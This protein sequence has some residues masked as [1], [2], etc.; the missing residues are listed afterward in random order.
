[1]PADSAR[2]TTAVQMSPISSSQT[3]YTLRL[4]IRV[5]YGTIGA[6]SVLSESISLFSRYSWLFG[7]LEG[8]LGYWWVRRH[9]QQLLTMTRDFIVLFVLS[10]LERFIRGERFRYFDADFSDSFR[11]LFIIRRFVYVYFVHCS[12]KRR[13]PILFTFVVVAFGLPPEFWASFI[14]AM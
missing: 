1:M 10:K 4:N 11:F 5:V 3:L 2:I 9:F 7:G 13:S 12:S 8:L 6:Q 14:F